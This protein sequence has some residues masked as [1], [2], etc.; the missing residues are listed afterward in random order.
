MRYT[1]LL[2]TLL[3][4]TAGTGVVGAL[5]AAA[6]TYYISPT[7]SDSG[8][9]TSAAPWRTLQKASA[10]MVAGDTAIAADGEYPGGITH[11]RDGTPTAPIS[12]R[13]ENP[14][15]AIIRGDQTTN[16]DAFFVDG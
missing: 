5:P 8:P 16:R 13:A 4:A 3:A 1:H 10:G 2:T 7:G 14:G 12:F 9:G 6:A 11:T 15:R